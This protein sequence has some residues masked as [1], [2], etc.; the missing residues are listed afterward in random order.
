MII[1]CDHCEVII[2]CKDDPSWK[3]FDDTWTDSLLH[4]FCPECT[5]LPAIQ[6]IIAQEKNAVKNAMEKRIQKEVLDAEFIG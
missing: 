3:V 4:H 5:E 1:Q 2:S 6:S